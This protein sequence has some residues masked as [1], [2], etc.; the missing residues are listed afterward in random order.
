MSE[1]WEK[2]F[3]ENEGPKNIESVIEQV[4][5]FCSSFSKPKSESISESEQKSESTSNEVPKIVLIT[6]GGTT[7]PFEK[8]T[9]RF[10]LL[11]FLVN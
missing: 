9:V 1:D 4:D 3:Q 5:K 7:I 2:F 6:S 11:Q 8:N 10:V